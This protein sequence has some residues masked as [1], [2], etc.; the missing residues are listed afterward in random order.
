VLTYDVHALCIA[1]GDLHSLGISV[2]LAGPPAKK[3]SIA[4]KFHGQKLPPNLEKLSDAR[5]FC[6]KFGRHYAQRDE[7]QI[8]L[9]LRE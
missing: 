7:K 5:I 2:G 4:E 8:F 9:V 3:Q 6:P 1:C